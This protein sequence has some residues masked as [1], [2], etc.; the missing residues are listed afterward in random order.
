MSEQQLHPRHPGIGKATHLIQAEGKSA[1]EGGFF[2]FL[3]S[4]ATKSVAWRS[5]TPITPTLEAAKKY[6][7]KVIE[8]LQADGLTADIDRTNWASVTAAIQR[9]ILDFN[10]GLRSRISDA[11]GKHF[12]A[13][14]DP[15]RLMH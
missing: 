1:E 12:G 10:T 4:G 8:Q 11:W 3:P 2:V 13:G 14:G 15:T 5:A 9:V 6:A 7:S